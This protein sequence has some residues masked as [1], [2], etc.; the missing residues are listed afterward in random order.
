MLLV[1]QLLIEGMQHVPFLSGAAEKGGLPVR[2]IFQE[3]MKPVPGRFAC[4]RRLSLATHAVF[5]HAL[6]G[7]AEE[8][9]VITG[10]FVSKPG[11]VLFLRSSEYI[12]EDNNGRHSS[13]ADIP[14][15]VQTLGP[16]LQSLL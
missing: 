7:T 6:E 9:S 12:P 8:S 14:Y 16:L 1:K 3:I 13:S 15:P 10:S 2:A 5:R 11:F 4:G